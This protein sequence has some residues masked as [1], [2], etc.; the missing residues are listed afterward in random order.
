MALASRGS[1]AARVVVVT[2]VFSWPE[3]RC[4][5]AYGC[6]PPDARFNGPQEPV[7]TDVWLLRIVDLVML[8]GFLRSET[9]L[10]GGL[11]SPAEVSALATPAGPPG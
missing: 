7:E 2:A 1:S 3:V 6:V 11:G 4:L 10:A 9:R 5:L 8:G